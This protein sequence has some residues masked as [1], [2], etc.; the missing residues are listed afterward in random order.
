M[1]IKSQWIALLVLAAQ[2]ALWPIPT[3]AEEAYE[4]FEAEVSFNNRY[5]FEDHLYDGQLNNYMSLATQ[6]EYSYEYGNH[7]F[8]ANYFARLD[9]YDT[10]RTHVDIREMYYLYYKGNWEFSAGLKKVFWG[11]TE[12]AHLVDIINQTDQVESTDGEQKL[13]QPMINAVYSSDYGNF[14]LFYLPYS[15]RRQ[16]PSRKGRFRFEPAIDREFIPFDPDANA[17]EWQ[18]T[19][20]FRYSHYIDA[21]DFAISHFYGMGREPLFLG[22]NTPDFEFYYPMINQTGLEMQLTLEDILLKAEATYRDALRKEGPFKNSKAL[23]F[24]AAVAG[25]EYT[26]SNIA[27][28][29]LDIGIVGEYLYDERE[30]LSV[31]SLDN[32]I[33]GGLRFA[34]NDTQSTDFLIGGIFDLEQSTKLFSFQGSRRVFDTWKVE[35]IA[36][37]FE[38]VSR[39]EFLYF[40]RQ[41]DYLEIN[42]SKFF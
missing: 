20:A 5:F 42:I 26:F 36:N 33:F 24:F 7:S 10:N 41:D 31:T 28:S 30:E 39:Q 25:F 27:S 9:Q 4:E 2:S 23:S 14:S 6:L 11:V 19:A 37:V 40:F 13:G 21:F 18:P 12:S 34:F 38:T 32:D 16:F 22:I 15:R 35:I 17:K 29:G 3:V 8:K 1:K